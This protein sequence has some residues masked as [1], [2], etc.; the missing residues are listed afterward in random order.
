MV[1]AVENGY[2]VLP[3]PQQKTAGVRFDFM[4]AFRLRFEK[5]EQ[6]NQIY[7]WAGVQPGRKKS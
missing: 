3:T 1:Q 7:D 6:E 4:A 2:E 5:P